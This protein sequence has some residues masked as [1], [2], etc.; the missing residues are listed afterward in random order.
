M[1]PGSYKSD[2][3]INVTGIDKVH[4][5]CD[6]I[7]AGIMNGTRKPILY[8]FALFSSPGRKLFKE[9]RTKLI[10]KLNKSVLSQT[11][12]FLEND[13]HKPVDFHNET[14]SFNCQ[15]IKT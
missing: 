7:N 6:Y 13:D 12:F 5:K 15:L 14:I 9:P 3:P 1:I 10:K 2:K 11:K 8:S 4:S